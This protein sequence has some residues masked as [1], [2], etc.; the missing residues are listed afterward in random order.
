MNNSVNF[1]SDSLALSAF[2]FLTTE[3]EYFA[4]Y[5][6]NTTILTDKDF[7]N[8]A[9]YIY[10]KIHDSNKNKELKAIS[11]LKLVAIE[12]LRK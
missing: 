12:I 7:D 4:D 6:N 5:F 10:K 9:K 8:W 2:D 11:K 3:T 1:Y